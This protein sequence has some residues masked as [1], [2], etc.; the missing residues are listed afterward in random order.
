MRVLNIKQHLG[1]E[2]TKII[3]HLTVFDDATLLTLLSLIIY[4]F[5]L[6]EALL[7]TETIRPLE[8]NKV[9]K[10]SKFFINSIISKI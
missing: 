3:D 2:G 10:H 5:D 8:V 9:G 4:Y 7:T 1:W 6:L